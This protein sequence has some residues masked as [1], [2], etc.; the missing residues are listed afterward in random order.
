MPSSKAPID[1]VVDPL[2]KRRMERKF[3]MKDRDLSVVRR[4][5][6]TNCTRIIHE[7]KVNRIHT[8]YFDDDRLSAYCENKDGVGR[9]WKARLRWYNR[10]NRHNIF[11]E[12]KHRYNTISQKDRFELT[13]PES[14][15]DLS[16]RDL[17]RQLKAQLPYAMY[18]RFVFRSD[19]ILLN[20]YAREYFYDHYHNIRL[21]LDYD[22]RCFNQMGHRKISRAYPHALE[23]VIIL[24]CKLPVD[25]AHDLEQ[26]LS[27]LRL[28]VTRSSKYVQCLERLGCGIED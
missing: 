25:F 14:I 27:P 10:S 23:G 22:M 8:L 1:F 20:E 16:F 2:A 4:I 24:E 9:R 21:T 19:P 3:W 5:L 7:D 13:L 11:F 17:K 26:T 6:E 18:E 15:D 28:R 12:F